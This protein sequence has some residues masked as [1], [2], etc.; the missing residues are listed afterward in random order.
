MLKA[1]TTLSAATSKTSAVEREDLQPYWKSEK[2]PQTL[3]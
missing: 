3:R 1:Q 2:R